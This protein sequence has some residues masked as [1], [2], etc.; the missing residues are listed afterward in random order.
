M[1]REGLA[2]RRLF[3][4]AMIL[5]PVLLLGSSIAFAAG[6]GRDLRDRGRGIA[7]LREQLA[8]RVEDVAA[9]LCGL[10]STP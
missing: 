2:H 3:A 5:G 6:G 1:E 4:G 10:A 7:L 8:G 9:R